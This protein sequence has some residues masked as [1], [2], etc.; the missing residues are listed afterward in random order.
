MQRTNWTIG[1]MSVFL[2]ASIGKADDVKIYREVEGW[3]PYFYGE[4]GKTYVSTSEEYSRIDLG[5]KAQDWYLTTLN[6]A[7]PM[8]NMVPYLEVAEYDRNGI[9]G[10]TYTAGSYFKL[11]K[12]ILQVEAGGR[13]GAN[14]LYRAETTVEYQYYVC[15]NFY[16]KMKARYMNYG[17]NDVYVGSP[18]GAV[19]YF[20]PHYVVAD[21]DAS[22]TERRGAAYWGSVKANFVINP[23]FEIYAGTVVGQRVFD[24]SGIT[25][26]AGQQLGFI[27][28]VGG[29]FR[30]MEN[31]QLR[32]GCSYSEE[33]PSFKKRSVDLALSMR[34]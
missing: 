20:G 25:V 15:E 2:M 6:V 22:E 26:D 21:L 9:N 3:S 14:Y 34:F 8:T 7:F 17:A 1:I 24:I 5:G 10:Y 30:V 28:F 19:Y 33:E 18:V 12:D 4:P 29:T 23:R 11:G 31:M 27:T 32:V 13:S 16:G